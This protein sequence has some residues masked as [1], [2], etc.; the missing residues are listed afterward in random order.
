MS[1]RNATNVFHYSNG[2]LQPFAQLGWWQWM[3]RLS[4]YSYLIEGLLGQGKCYQPPSRSL[5]KTLRCSCWK[6]EHNVLLHRA[7][8]A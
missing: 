2:V 5:S 7:R 3:Y 8:H 6:A 4:P 1:F